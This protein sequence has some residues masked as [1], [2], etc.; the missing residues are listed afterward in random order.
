[1]ICLKKSYLGVLLFSF[2]IITS[3]SLDPNSGSDDVNSMNLE[4]AYFVEDGILSFTTREAYEETLN[5]L[6]KMK[7]EELDSWQKELDP[8]FIS[9]RSA[10]NLLDENSELNL[11]TKLMGNF[12]GGYYTVVKEKSGELEIVRTIDSN[13][14]ATVANENGILKIGSKFYSISYD[15]L[16]EFENSEILKSLTFEAINNNDIGNSVRV[17]NISRSV[18]Q[19][20][21]ETAAKVGTC[22]DEYRN[23]WRFRAEL[24]VTNTGPIYSGTGARAK[25]QKKVLGAWFAK[26]ADII[27][28]DVDG[29]FSQTG[30]GPGTVTE[31]IDF[32]TTRY[33]DANIDY[34]WNECFNVACSFDASATVKVEGVERDRPGSCTIL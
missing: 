12:H 28:L 7:P 6:S 27:T 21:E 3:C 29:W 32:T 31:N 10:F 4:N 18:S 16:F 9:S 33:D 5:L 23:N 8:E 34:A 17:F 14:L 2:L 11:P 26:S 20:G 24:W 25:H 15:R 1:M 13:A 19:V 30:P 22:N